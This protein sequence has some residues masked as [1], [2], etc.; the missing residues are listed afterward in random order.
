M[1]L[2]SYLLHVGL[3]K[4]PMSQREALSMRQKYLSSEAQIYQ[5]PSSLTLK[6]LS[7]GFLSI[8]YIP[9]SGKEGLGPVGTPVCASQAYT[10]ES[11]GTFWDAESSLHTQPCP[12]YIRR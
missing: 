8:T 2:D 12:I 10:V 3:S 11:L 9:V 7:L 4:L 1:G 5:W 6:F